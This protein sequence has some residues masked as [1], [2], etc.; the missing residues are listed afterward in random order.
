MKDLEVNIILIMK[1]QMTNKSMNN[2]C[3]NEGSRIQRSKVDQ[4]GY[5]LN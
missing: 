5:W 1:V 3:K 2:N 4:V